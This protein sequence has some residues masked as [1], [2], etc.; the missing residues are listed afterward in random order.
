MGIYTNIKGRSNYYHRKPFNLT[1][2]YFIEWY[3]S[4]P[5]VCAYCDIPEEY[6]TLLEYSYGTKTDKLTV[7]CKDNYLGYV[8]GNLSLSCMKCNSIKNDVFSFDDM[9][10]IA[11]KYI[12]PQWMALVKKEKDEK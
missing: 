10:E 6:V 8:E 5:R 4:Q 1:K 9:R 7:D 3:N 2:E 12:K 11:Q